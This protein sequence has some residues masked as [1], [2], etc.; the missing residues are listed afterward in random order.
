MGKEGALI[1]DATLKIKK[2]LD[3]TNFEETED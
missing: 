3:P 2:I 1:I